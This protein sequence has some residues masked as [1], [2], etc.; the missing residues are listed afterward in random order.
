MDA[1]TAC[2][3]IEINGG[4][5]IDNNIHISYKTSSIWHD[6]L[7]AVSTISKYTENMNDPIMHKMEIS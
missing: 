2:K 7:K 5:N 6:M 1:I 4:N 3:N